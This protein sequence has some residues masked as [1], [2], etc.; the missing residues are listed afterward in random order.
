MGFYLVLAAALI[1]EP[2]ASERRRIFNCVYADE[3]THN[4]FLEVQVSA[5]ID[6]FVPTKRGQCSV[7][8]P[9]SYRSKSAWVMHQQLVGSLSL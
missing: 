8:C 6:L 2:F 9:R 3:T 4:G 1:S 5:S 7:T